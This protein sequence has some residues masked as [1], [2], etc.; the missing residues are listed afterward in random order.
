MT[1]IEKI[2]EMIAEGETERSLKE[3][4]DYVKENNADVI[5]KLIMLRNRMQ[6]LQNSLSIGTIDE[7]DAS[8][9]RAKINEAILKL[10]PQLTPEYLAQAAQKVE[11][12]H[13]ERQAAP[14]PTRNKNL[15]YIIGGAAAL[16]IIFLIVKFAN[17][18]ST[19]VEDSEAPQ[20]STVDEN[21]TTQESTLLSEISA[22]GLV[23]V[24]NDGANIFQFENDKICQEV[25]NGQITN[26]FDVIEGADPLEYITLHDSDRN[27]YLRIG[28]T[29]V[30]IDKGEEDTWDWNDLYSGE[31]V[32][33]S[34][35]E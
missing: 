12:V 25:V 10:L 26:T 6:N 7:Q 27:M 17:N 20:E 4:Y 13:P 19:I 35:N 33:P 9:E 34:E 11:M 5:D 28:K 24:S 16:L 31:W 29:T 1:L 30:Q 22:N 23:W 3:L 32:K 21:L 15:L 18:N 14:P 2:R 8:I